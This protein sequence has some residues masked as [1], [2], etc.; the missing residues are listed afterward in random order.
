MGQPHEVRLANG[1]KIDWRHPPRPNALCRWT[2]ETA[3]GKVIRGGFRTLCHFNRLNNLSIAKFDTQLVIF[4]GP[5][6]DSVPAS[7][8]THDEDACMDWYIPGLGWWATQAFGRNNGCGC[9]YRHPPLFSNHI[10]GFTLPPHSGNPAD[11]FKVAGIKVGKFID[12]GLSSLGR[13]AG[14]AQISD[15]YH[16]AFGLSG[17]HEPGSDHSWFPRDIGKTIFDLEDYVSRRAA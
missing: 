1:A 11:D 10:H 4:Q 9:W 7:K 15:Y 2:K 8:G 17:A 5:F 13:V 3:S 6:N 12:G 16:H 14:S